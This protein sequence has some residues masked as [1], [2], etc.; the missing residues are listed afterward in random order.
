[1]TAKFCIY[2]SCFDNYFMRDLFGK[3]DPCAQSLDE[4]SPL[5]LKILQM[6]L[7]ILSLKVGYFKEVQYV[8]HD[9]DN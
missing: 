2:K 9:V 6:R 4:M 7:T 1:M 8:N 3:I 5:I